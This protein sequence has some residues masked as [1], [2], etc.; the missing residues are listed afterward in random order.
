MHR[1]TA[2]L[3]NVTPSLMRIPAVI[4]RGLAE[5]GAMCLTTP[6]NQAQPVRSR[7][8]RDRDADLPPSHLRR[9]A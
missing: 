9:R 8:E 6:P 3:T 1:S 4:W 5:A 7:H 2:N